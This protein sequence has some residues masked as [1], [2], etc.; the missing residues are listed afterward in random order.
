MSSQ[1]DRNN[2]QVSMLHIPVT[3]TSQKGEDV[4]VYWSAQTDQLDPEAALSHHFNTNRPAPADHLFAWRHPNGLQPLTQGAFMT[5]LKDLCRSLDIE[6]LQG[7]GIRIGGTLELL[8]R[9]VP[10]DITK[11]IGHWSSQAF[12]VYLCDH[13]IVMAPY[14]QNT[15]IL[16]PFL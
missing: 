8:L 16:K 5:T 15:L 12:L 1:L 7:H 3:R 4:H 9:G 2:F 14:M 10:F 6:C 11:T 13:A